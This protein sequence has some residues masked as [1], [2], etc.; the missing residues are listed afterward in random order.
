MLKHIDYSIADKEWV[1]ENPHIQKDSV[2]RFKTPLSRKH[3]ADPKNYQKKSPDWDKLGYQTARNRFGNN[4]RSMS[5]Q[6]WFTF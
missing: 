5:Q 6:S 2:L 4:K 3:I 1:Q